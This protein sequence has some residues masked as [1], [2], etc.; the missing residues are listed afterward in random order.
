[1]RKR[2][3]IADITR[4]VGHLAGLKAVA[5]NLRNAVY[6]IKQLLN[7]IPDRVC[8]GQRR[9]ILG[10]GRADKLAPG[11]SELAE[12]TVEFFNLITVRAHKEFNIYI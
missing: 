6:E 7:L 9:S 2:A 4:S 3:D 8:R 11:V 10:R 5:V 12:T 1:M